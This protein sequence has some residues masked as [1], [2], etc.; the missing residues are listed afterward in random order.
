MKAEQTTPSLHIVSFISRPCFSNQAL[1]NPHNLPFKQIHHTV[2]S[3]TYLH[4]CDTPSLSHR[5]ASRRYV[6]HACS[7]THTHLSIHTPYPSTRR[8]LL[9]CH[10][11]SFTQWLP[12][13]QAKEGWNSHIGVSF[14]FHSVVTFNHSSGVPCFSKLPCLFAV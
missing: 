12:K 10:T 3:L 14:I 1:P 2:L 11:N 9:F 7:L 13:I 4:S 6:R 8:P 5:G